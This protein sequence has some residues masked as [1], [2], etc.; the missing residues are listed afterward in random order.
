MK[1]VDWIFVTHKGG[2]ISYHDPHIPSIK[3]N[4]GHQYNSVELTSEALAKV[5]CV[6]LTTN[7]S[8]FNVDF[9]QKHAKMIVDLR[10]MVKES[11]D[12]VYKL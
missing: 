2:E 10:N 7:H 5:D 1:S 12:T 4:A 8:A 9:I 6:V 3:T 11:T